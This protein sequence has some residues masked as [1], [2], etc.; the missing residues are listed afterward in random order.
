VLKS[1]LTSVSQHHISR[2]V[3]ELTMGGGCISASSTTLCCRVL[4]PFPCN[5]RVA[6][7][8]HRRS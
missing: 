7:L 8:Y 3:L 5:R 1:Q 4:T 6:Q 2:M